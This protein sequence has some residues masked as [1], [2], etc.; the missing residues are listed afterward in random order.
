MCFAADEPV[1][2]ED[3][4]IEKRGL[5]GLG[6]GAGYYPTGYAGYA[7]YGGYGHGGYGG[8]GHAA[9]YYGGAYPATS[10][11]NSYNSYASPLRY[12][13]GA[14]P[15]V[16]GYGGYAGYG[17][18]GAYSHGLGGHGYNSYLNSPYSSYY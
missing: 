8:Y 1:A 4:K 12:G 10:Y 11:Y 9:P 18:Y 5:L 15:Y 17:G 2:A 6:Y 16:R 7:G 3:K 13:Y 14:S